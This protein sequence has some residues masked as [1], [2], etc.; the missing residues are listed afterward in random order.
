MLQSSWSSFE[1]NWLMIMRTVIYRKS[2]VWYWEVLLVVPS[3]LWLQ[4]FIGFLQGEKWRF[5]PSRLKFFLDRTTGLTV[6]QTKKYRSKGKI[7]RW[8]I[9]REEETRKIRTKNYSKSKVDRWNMQKEG[10]SFENPILEEPLNE[11]CCNIIST[12]LNMFASLLTLCLSLWNHNL[13]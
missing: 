13:L 2:I 6:R 5:R 1:S 9:Q 7:D 4:S 11:N 10:E 3:L 8:N 12:C